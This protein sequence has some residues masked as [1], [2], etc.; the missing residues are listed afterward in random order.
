MPR[1]NLTDTRV[2]MTPETT[3]RMSQDELAGK[4]AGRQEFVGF[5]IPSGPVQFLALDGSIKTHNPASTHRFGGPRLIVSERRLRRIVY[6][7][8]G[9]VRLAGADEFY[10]GTNDC[11]V[12][13]TSPIAV[14][15]VTQ[16]VQEVQ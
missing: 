13:G 10:L 5:E 8:T 15:I 1:I 7:E 12:Q 3:Y 6:T 4:L 14:P 16:E 11:A 2:E 9:E